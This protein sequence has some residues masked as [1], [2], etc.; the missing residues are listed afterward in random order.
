MARFFSHKVPTLY[1]KRNNNVPVSLE[2][3]CRRVSYVIAPATRASG[4]ANYE[5]GWSEEKDA[6]AGKRDRGWK[7]HRDVLYVTYVHMSCAQYTPRNSHRHIRRILGSHTRA[8]SA[9][10]PCSTSRRPSLS[11][12]KNIAWTFI[13]RRKEKKKKKKEKGKC[14]TKLRSSRKDWGEGGEVPITFRG[15]AADFSVAISSNRVINDADLR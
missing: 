11:L 13:G 15:L 1:T 3:T 5:S 9:F 14:N 4:L 6:A 7:I 10:T 8:R 12:W 2:P